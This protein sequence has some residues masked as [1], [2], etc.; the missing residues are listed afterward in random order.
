MNDLISEIA[1]IFAKNLSDA[2]LLSASEIR[3]LKSSGAP[4]SQ[5][6][7]NQELVSAETSTFTKR[8]RYKVGD[9]VMAMLV[10][11]THPVKMRISDVLE[12]LVYLAYFQGCSKSAIREIAHDQVLGLDPDR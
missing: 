2:L 11:G 1:I 4:L 7:K 9:R 5:A 6:D 8:D 12:G 10:G 3:K